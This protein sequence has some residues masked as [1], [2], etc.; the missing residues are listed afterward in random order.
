MP[1]MAVRAAGRALVSLF[2]AAVLAVVTIVLPNASE[3]F[4]T[5]DRGM[6]DARELER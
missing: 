1:A 4:D 6:R 2:A 5:V 3:G